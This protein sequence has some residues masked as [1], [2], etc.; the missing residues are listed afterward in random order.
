MMTSDWLGGALAVSVG[1]ILGLIFFAGLW[2]TVKRAVTSPHPALW[3]IGSMLIRVA[4]TL[5]GFYWV[6]ADQWWRLLLCT[7][8][9]IVARPVVSRT[10]NQPDTGRRTPCN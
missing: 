2:W 5:V 6:S 3:F 1:F 9:F 4:I 8:G 10:V 7:A